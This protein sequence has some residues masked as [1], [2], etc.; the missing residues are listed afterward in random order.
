MHIIEKQDSIPEL[1]VFLKSE[2]VLDLREKCNAP[3]APYNIL[4]D[5]D[6]EAVGIQF[7]IVLIVRISN[8][9]DSSAFYPLT[10]VG[11][12]P[13]NMLDVPHTYPCASA[14]AADR[15]VPLSVIRPVV[16]PISPRLVSRHLP[17][18]V[19]Q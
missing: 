17:R 18:V 5:S 6:S 10:V 13:R 12:A 3:C 11:T 1:A 16:E 4:E 19:F 9:A 15:R 7:T 2:I 14:H 8:Y